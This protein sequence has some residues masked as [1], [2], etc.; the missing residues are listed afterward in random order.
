MHLFTPFHVV[1]INIIAYTI[2]FLPCINHDCLSKTLT[3]C[4]DCFRT[5]QKPNSAHLDHHQAL[6]SGPK[7]V[8]AVVHPYNFPK[9]CCLSCKG[10]P[11]IHFC[12]IMGMVLIIYARSSIL[13]CC[14]PDGISNAAGLESA[15]THPVTIGTEAET[16]F[17][18]SRQNLCP[19]RSLHKCNTIV[20]IPCIFD[21]YI[22]WLICLCS[23]LPIRV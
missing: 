11:L 19:P 23:Q 5:A 4:S 2:P 6:Q 16:R 15:S 8:F 9:S 10:P 3:K 21:Y 17:L 20:D 14:R 7:C 1:T 12:T 13:W 18:I 22:L